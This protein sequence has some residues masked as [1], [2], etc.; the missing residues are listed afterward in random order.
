MAQKPTGKGKGKG[1]GKS[2]P[3]TAVSAKPSG[4]AIPTGGAKPPGKPAGAPTKFNAERT[5]RILIAARAGAMTDALA[6]AYGGVA[7][8]TMREWIKKGELVAPDSTDAELVPYREFSESYKAARVE[9]EIEATLAIR[10]AGHG[11]VDP[12]TGRY[13]IDPD[14]KAFAWW[15]E[16]RRP[17]EYGRP[18]RLMGA[19]GGP[20]IVK[21]ITDEDRAKRLSKL[22]AKSG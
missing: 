21:A 9:A 2:K 20:V 10:S 22:L 13:I 14:W 12:K 3:A 18:V 19:A 8:D 6:A 16:R 1:K 15:L 7:Y 5:K 17:S 4:S 11:K